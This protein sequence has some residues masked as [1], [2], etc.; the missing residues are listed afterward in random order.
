MRS[1]ENPASVVCRNIHLLIL[2]VFSWLADFGVWLYRKDQKAV[3][4][5][6]ATLSLILTLHLR[7]AF[8]S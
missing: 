2:E 8:V 5:A 7:T 6:D 1:S 4:G 3:V